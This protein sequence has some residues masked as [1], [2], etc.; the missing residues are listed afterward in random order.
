MGGW[1]YKYGKFLAF[2]TE[3][4]GLETDGVDAEPDEV[5]GVAFYV[6]NRERQPLEKFVVYA[7]PS[8]MEKFSAGALRTNG[9]T[10]EAW[11]RRGAVTQAE[12]ARQVNAFLARYRKRKYLHRLEMLCYNVEFD[13]KM[14]NNLLKKHGYQELPVRTTSFDTMLRARYYDQRFTKGYHDSYK[15]K[16]VCSRFGIEGKWHTA[17]GDI[18]ATIALDKAIETAM[19]TGIPVP[20]SLRPVPENIQEYPHDPP[21]VVNFIPPPPE[22]KTVPPPPTSSV[23]LP[24]PP[25]IATPFPEAEPLSDMTPAM[26]DVVVL[27][28]EKSVL[29]Q[30][31]DSRLAKVE[32]R[33]DTLDGK[34]D[35]LKAGQDSMMELL[36]G[37]LL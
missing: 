24:S 23:T 33:V 25:A 22:G 11:A 35:A 27:T 29:S 18:L 31:E 14:V 6:L 16:D 12:L 32:E 4:T 2:D 15:L 19:E 34:V 20:G 30:G 26:D 10:E 9:Y 1:D 5:V 13:R 17:D 3:T 37:K 36:K 21:N 8:S 7:H 28:G